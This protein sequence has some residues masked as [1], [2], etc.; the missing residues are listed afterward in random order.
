MT[1]ASCRTAQRRPAPYGPGPGQGCKKGAGVRMPG[2][3]QLNFEGQDL[4]QVTLSRIR[5]HEPPE[6]YYVAFSGGKDSVVLFDLVQRAGVKFDAHYNVTGIDPP[7]LVYFIR[8]FYPDVI[9]EM[10]LK[11]IWPLVEAKGLPRRTARFCCEYLK[12]HSGAGRLVVTGIRW[13]ESV[14]RRRRQM[15]E[16]CR[17]HRAKF[18]LHPIIDWPT[19][20]VWSYIHREGLPYCR[21]Y[22]EGFKRLGCVLCP[23]G[24]PA[25]AQLDMARWPKI[26]AAWRRAA[27]RF[28]NRGTP[29]TRRWRTAAEY[30]DWWLTREATPDPGDCQLDLFV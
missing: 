4:V 8:D 16:S 11:R 10:P 23:M 21:L 7:E 3:D 28:Y 14:A 5:E 15:L 26:A 22:D 20:S 12:E 25:Q 6:G 1:P 24:S 9:P 27:G 18:F 19:E 30:L 17:W 29:G 13:A 2:L